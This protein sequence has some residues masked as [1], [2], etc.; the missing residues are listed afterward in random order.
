[1]LGKYNFIRRSPAVGSP[2]PAKAAPVVVASPALP[3]NISGLIALLLKP[4]SVPA[5]LTDPGLEINNLP[6][7][8]ASE[9][10]IFGTARLF[11][12]AT[13]AGA[14]TAQIAGTGQVL[15]E[16]TNPEVVIPGVVLEFSTNASTSQPTPIAGRLRGTYQGAVK[17]ADATGALRA[18]GAAFEQ[19]DFDTGVFMVTPKSLGQKYTMVV[20][21]HQVVNSRTYLRPLSLGAALTRFVEASP[22]VLDIN[23]GPTGLVSTVT[24]L[25]PTH[26][27]F[28]DV[29]RALTQKDFLA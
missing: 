4:T 9:S 21:G 14:L 11:E 1:M 13:P 29:V 16:T 15:L 7:D 12:A 23:S 22:L 2:A 28:P 24:A 25:T 6:I 3:G 5:I 27:I 19:L 18:R 20:L 17:Y 26:S 8:S 10:G